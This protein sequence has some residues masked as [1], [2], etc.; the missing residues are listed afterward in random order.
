MRLSP[1]LVYFFYRI[2][3]ALW[4]IKIVEHPDVTAKIKAGQPLILAHWHGDELALFH[5]VRPY[6]L[7]TMTS[8]SRDGEIVDF[9]IRKLGGDTSRGSSTRGGVAALKGLIRLC[10]SGRIVSIAVDG[11]RGPIY[12][13]KPGVFELSKIC[14]AAIVPVGVV[15]NHS[16]VFKNAWNKAFLPLPGSKVV[17]YFAQ[18]IAPLL[19][20]EEPKNMALA[21]T[22]T[23]QLGAAKQQAA[24]II[25]AQ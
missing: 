15:A 16:F 20:N 17:I 24:K 10:R 2:L 19:E 11:P 23:S 5:L 21:T 18:P 22:H 4:R 14:G 12:Q 8:T 1:W 6:N 25:A 7:A 13:P 3:I 9:L